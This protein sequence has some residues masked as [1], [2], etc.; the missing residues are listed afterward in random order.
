VEV[1]A[2]SECNDNLFWHDATTVDAVIPCSS[3]LVDRPRSLLPFLIDGLFS[4]ESTSSHT[5]QVQIDKDSQEAI[6]SVQNTGSPAVKGNG[7]L[8]TPVSP[9]L[10]HSSSFSPFRR[11]DPPPS[12]TSTHF[13]AHSSLLHPSSFPFFPQALGLFSHALGSASTGF[14]YTC[15]S[16]VTLDPWGASPF[17]FFPVLSPVFSIV[18]SFISCP[19]VS[20][21]SFPRLSVCAANPI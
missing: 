16:F 20:S 1:F 9:R 18:S 15:C 12:F 7:I 19:R 6:F 2:L 3:T 10:A 21:Y 11:S 13:D 8:H 4:P 5:D 17:L 14:F